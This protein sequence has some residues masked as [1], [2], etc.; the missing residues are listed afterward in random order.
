MLTSPTISGLL[1][2]LCCLSSLPSCFSSFRVL[3][4]SISFVLVF[5]KW[6]VTSSTHFLKQPVRMR[7]NGLILMLAQIPGLST[8]GTYTTILPLLFFV[9][10]TI[11]KEGYDDYRRHRLDTVENASFA[12]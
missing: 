2:I 10:L 4:T 9:L 6:Y 1:A 11:V 3:E 12:T 7:L 5:R 8:T